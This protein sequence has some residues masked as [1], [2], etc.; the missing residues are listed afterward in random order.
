MADKNIERDK[1]IIDL[2][3]DIKAI[4]EKQLA[5]ARENQ[6][7]LQKERKEVK[8]YR[9]LGKASMRRNTMFSRIFMVFLVL[10][11]IFMILFT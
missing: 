5:L 8:E 7:E 9:Q 11:V 4:N 3:R 10:F 1:Q 6:K 2:L